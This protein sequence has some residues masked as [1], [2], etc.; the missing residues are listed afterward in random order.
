MNCIRDEMQKPEI[1]DNSKFFE[2][3]NLYEMKPK[4]ISYVSWILY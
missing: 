1:K 4:S 2:T 3:S